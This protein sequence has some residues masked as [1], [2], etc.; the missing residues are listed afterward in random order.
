MLPTAQVGKNAYALPAL[1]ASQLGIAAIIAG[2]LAGSS[3]VPSQYNDPNLA[4]SAYTAGPL[5]EYIAYVMAQAGRPVLAMKSSPSVA[6]TYGTI[7][8]GGLG[9]GGV[10][11]GTFT[12]SATSSTFPL[13]NYNVVVTFLVGGTLGS[14]GITYQ[15]VLDGP[16]GPTG[17]VSGNIVGPAALGTAVV[18][19]IPNTN[20]SFTLATSGTS[21]VVA[22]DFFQVATQ[23]A[24]NSDSDNTTALNTL[25]LTRQPWE[26]VMIDNNFGTASVG[27]VDGILATLET[28]GQFKFFLMNTPYKI[29][30]LPTGETEAAYATRIGNLLGT[31][32][33]NRGCVG[34]D[35]GHVASTV[36]GLNL[37]RPTMLALMGMAMS[38][39]PNFGVDPAYVGDGPVPGFVLTDALSNPYDHDEDLYPDL[40]GLGFSTLRSFAQPAGPAGCYLANANVI[41]PSTSNIR[42]LQQ[43]RVLNQAC[44]IAWS[45]LTA[46]L[47]LGVQV[48]VNP[49]TNQL[50]IKE[51]DAQQIETWVNPQLESALAGQISTINGVPGVALAISRTDNLGVAPATVSGTVNVVGLAYIKGFSV[52]V[53]FSKTIAAPLS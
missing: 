14:A 41:S 10:Q 1:P 5:V 31:Q 34:A 32:T 11:Q 19:A 3:L 50:N 20:V 30:P 6:A 28:K 44:S 36:T 12:V 29:Q 27:V 51:S 45:L 23:R 33:S 39:T 22:G 24:L 13:D 53:A 15:Y 43:L 49:T 42:Y 8:T 38:L 26:G 4:A 17:P 9:T 46:R 7:T 48:A 18:I 2:A 25:A 52:K 47:S 16:S 35:G 21:T 37:K 40:D